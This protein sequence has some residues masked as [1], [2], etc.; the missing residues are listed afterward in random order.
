MSSTRPIKIFD[1][2]LRDGEQS[3][4]CAMQLGE[5]LALASQLERLGVDVIE[6]GFAIASPGDFE[7]V[8]LIAQNVQNAV[9][10]SLARALPTDI[11]RAFEA[12]AKAQSPR[13]HTFIATSPL[14][15]AYKLKMRPDEV[16]ENVSSMIKYAKSKVNDIEF[17]AEDATRS[18]LPFLAKVVDTAI[19]AGATTINIPDTVGYATPE[20]YGN[21]L[22]ELFQ[23]S[24]HL[25]KV[26]LSVHCHND[27]GLAVANSLTAIG[28]GA[29][30]IECTV[31]GIGERAGNAALEEIVMAMVT[32]QDFYQ[33][34]TRIVTTEI[35]KTSRLLSSITGVIIAP[36]KPIVGANAFSHE[37]GIHQHGV[38]AHPSTYEIMTPE[39]VGLTK[40][41]MVLGK[42]SGRHGFMQ[43]VT[44]LGY[45][46]DEHQLNLAFEAFKRLADKKKEIYD[47]DIL[48]ILRQDLAHELPLSLKL[49][50]FTINSS[51]ETS[52][53]ATIHL[54]DSQ[55]K[56]YC[57]VSLGD[58]PIDAA[59][60]AI[61]QIIALHPTYHSLSFCL[62]TYG[63]RAL[64]EGDDAQGE[65]SVRLGL[66]GKSITGIGLS[67]DVLEASILA[68]INSVNKH[69]ALSQPKKGVV[70]YDAPSHDHDTKNISSPCGA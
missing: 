30:Q 15:M 50:R 68:Y 3:P 63:I 55:S 23:L 17:S 12:I 48:S 53:T 46:L 65:A 62:E 9:V 8:K 32:R 43:R 5:K 36:T 28:L 42:H 61:S 35:A 27:L 29:T 67:T 25:S 26:D 47:E 34:H 45:S 54:R 14:H 58:G 69:I 13:I 56:V 39:S 16:L 2:T 60:K 44:N 38:L 1:T 22:K 41:Q 19:E 21:F 59:Y 64:T 57:G 66:S 49:E 40:K 37:S 20:S 52:A 24:K 6:A 10:A 7:A 18:E 51:S 31:N 11:D 33:A 4:G 70:I